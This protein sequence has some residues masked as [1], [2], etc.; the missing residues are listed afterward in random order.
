VACPKSCDTSWAETRSRPIKS[1]WPRPAGHTSLARAH[2][3]GWYG[4]T[5]AGELDLAWAPILRAEFERLRHSPASLIV[6]D[7]RCLS[8]IDL[9][10][11][12]VLMTAHKRALRTGARLVIV[13]GPNAVHRLFELIRAEQSVFNVID[14]PAQARLERPLRIS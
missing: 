3:L 6:L 2:G 12:R 13:R 8:F 1:G 11:R 4:L 10:G 7:F 14:D 5:L 9:S